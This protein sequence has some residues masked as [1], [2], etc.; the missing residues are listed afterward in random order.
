ME[1]YYSTTFSSILFTFIPYKMNKVNFCF[2]FVFVF[3]L[4]R[5][6]VELNPFMCLSWY[7]WCVRFS[8][9]ASLFL[10]VSL[11]FH[12][13]FI[14][15]FAYSSSQVVFG[16]IISLDILFL[17][18]WHIIGKCLFSFKMTDLFMSSSNLEFSLSTDSTNLI[19]YHKSYHSM[20]GSV[21]SLH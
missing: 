5:R 6:L 1:I 18:K 21:F 2:C 16:Q 12:F 15:K 7:N 13:H 8:L 17:S 20:K 10:K 19:I 9:D 3:Y 11:F 4:I 14:Q